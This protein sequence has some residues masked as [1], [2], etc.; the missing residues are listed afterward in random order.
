MHKPVQT[1]VRIYSLL[2]KNQTYLK[3]LGVKRI[4]L[5]GSFVRGEQR[6]RSDVDFLIEFEPGNKSF[7]NF[8]R[9]SFFL[10]DLMGRRVE[11]ITPESLSP[12][13]GPRIIKEVEYAAVF[14]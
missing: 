6:A 10:E 1:K 5:F 13:I 11:L 4:G 8:I 3:S 12:Y 7:D 2:R 14:A 9:L